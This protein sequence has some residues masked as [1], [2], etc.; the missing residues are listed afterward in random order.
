M[1]H[2]RSIEG[3]GEDAA[4]E[5]DASIVFYEE[6]DPQ[7]AALRS[8]LD[9]RRRDEARVHATRL[10]EIATKLESLLRSDPA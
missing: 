9:A 6:L 10:G 4:R 8:A 3:G 2:L 1:T 5:A 7:V